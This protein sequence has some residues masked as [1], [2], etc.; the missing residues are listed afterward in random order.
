M[1]GMKIK[2]YK[3]NIKYSFNSYVAIPHQTGVLSQSLHLL[4]R[5]HP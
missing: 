1:H 3:I 4:K 5:N 2:K